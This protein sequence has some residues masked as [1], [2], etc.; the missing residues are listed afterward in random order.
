MLYNQ[1]VRRDLGIHH[2]RQGWWQASLSYYTDFKQM[3]PDPYHSVT[4]R[5]EVFY[6]GREGGGT[7]SGWNS[8]E[9]CSQMVRPFPKPALPLPAS[10]SVSRNGL[11]EQL[12]HL[13]AVLHGLKLQ[14]AI[15]RGGNNLRFWGLKLWKH[16]WVWPHC[17]PYRWFKCVWAGQ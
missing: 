9:K 16:I 8:A 2:F 3:P 13:P 7:T 17:E 4:T 14:L 6:S 15:E 12:Q 10:V 11:F 5:V 1:G